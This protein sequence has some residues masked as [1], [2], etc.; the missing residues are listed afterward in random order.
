[1]REKISKQNRFVSFLLALSV[2]VLT[3]AEINYA[4][5]LRKKS[6]FAKKYN[7]RVTLTYCKQKMDD[8]LTLQLF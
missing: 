3:M 6:A 5:T 2:A 1:M 4:A 8:Q 7:R